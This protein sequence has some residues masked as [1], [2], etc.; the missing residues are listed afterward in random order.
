MENNT[1][2]LKRRTL[3]EYLIDLRSQTG[4]EVTDGKNQ[5]KRLIYAETEL[6]AIKGS[7]LL[8]QCPSNELHVR[9][10]H[11]ADGLKNDIYKLV[12][13]MRE[14]GWKV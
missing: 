2:P 14:N 4:W 6:G 13:V 7:G 10:A 9:R 3:R 5:N 11:Y 1:I 12:D 8:R